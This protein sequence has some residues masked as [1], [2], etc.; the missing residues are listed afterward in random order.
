MA[1]RFTKEESLIACAYLTSFSDGGA[2]AE[3]NFIKNKLMPFYG[4]DKKV[5]WN[6]FLDK[7][8]TMIG[9]EGRS[10]IEK[11]CINTLKKTNYDMRVKACAG[12]W[13]VAYDVDEEWSS[14]ESKLFS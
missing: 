14:E 3:S 9:S 13:A 10:K 2:D 6:N 4:L 8:N 11:A 7:W 5:K 1:T 12:I